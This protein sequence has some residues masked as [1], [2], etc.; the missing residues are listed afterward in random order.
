MEFIE[1]IDGMFERDRS[2][3]CFHN[4]DNSSLGSSNPVCKIHIIG[5]CGAQHDN[6]DVLR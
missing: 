5:H 4:V 2:M 1:N 6:S 3:E